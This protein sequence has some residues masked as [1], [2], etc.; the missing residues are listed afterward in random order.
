MGSLG[1]VGTGSMLQ[2]ETEKTNGR[3]SANDV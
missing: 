3:I 1:V 2:E